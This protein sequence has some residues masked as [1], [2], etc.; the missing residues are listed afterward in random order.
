EER[1]VSD[2]IRLAQHAVA[3]LPR[4]PQL[5]R[6]LAVA[7]FDRS[8]TP[9]ATAALRRAEQAPLETAVYGGHSESVRA[10]AVD[11]A[12][13]LAATGSYDD[14]VRL[15]DLGPERDRE[16]A[17]S[18]QEYAGEV[19]GRHLENVDGV[20]FGGD[21]RLLA[22]AAS[23][24]VKIW[25]V[26]ERRR[27]AILRG[28]D[29]FG[30][31]AV[32]FSPD[33]ERVAA[34]GQTGFKGEEV[35]AVWSRTGGR[36][37][38]TLPVRQDALL[39]D[40][41]FAP[42]GS[43]IAT[44]GLG[45]PV[46]LWSLRSGAAVRRIDPGAGVADV[47]FS[48]DGRLLAVAAG[49]VVKIYDVDT[50]RARATLRGHNQFVTSVSFS[51]NGRL[52]VTGSEDDTA[53]VWEVRR[54]RVVA[55]LPAGGNVNAARFVPGRG[56]AV[57]TAGDDR[58]VRLWQL[59]PQPRAVLRPGPSGAS[60]LAY[61]AGGERLAAGLGDGSVATWSGGNRTTL[62]DRG[63]AVYS[64][65][66]SP[67]G[68]RLVTG[69]SAGTVRVWDVVRRDALA[70]FPAG[71]GPVWKAMFMPGDPDR[72]LSAMN[73]GPR[74]SAPAALWTWRDGRKVR[75]FGRLKGE[76]EVALSVDAD[77]TGSLVATADGGT[78]RPIL[79]NAATGRGRELWGHDGPVHMVAFAPRGRRLLTG[80]GDET[81]RLWNADTGR[82]LREID[83]GTVTGLGFGARDRLILAH[84]RS[85]VRVV[86]AD[87]GT[88]V[89]EFRRPGEQLWH[90][91]LSPDGRRVATTGSDLVV[92]VY[93]CEGC[94]N[95]DADA[96]RQRV[97]RQVGRELREDQI[98]RYLEEA[99]T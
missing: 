73:E 19:L 40:V 58:R 29:S 48:R 68:T 97:R 70:D 31:K 84:T 78:V 46:R 32:S 61:S 76:T 53:R 75:D 8:P 45:D 74:T 5:G 14:S 89:A 51:A 80:S 88:V 79:W 1:R 55:V 83:A 12:G 87:D 28:A 7:A 13:K 85:T 2:S 6:R 16:A 26:Q 67:D 92:R 38:R 57:A 81:V 64:L 71:R 17:S 10:L 91:V 60:Q 63:E 56:L 42:R 34:I 20:S 47:D 49:D 41:T 69:D 25:D 3:Q 44:G 95:R 96:L 50:G 59:A 35:V 22:S 94:I 62:P 65:G 15:W 72:V 82:T 39:S 98:E 93:D 30:W 33:A 52:L 36:P 11:G 99:P 18:R 23:S 27:T 37:V 24:A 77:S 90:A 86:A 21:G 43:L 9:Q 4:D 54:R 66:F